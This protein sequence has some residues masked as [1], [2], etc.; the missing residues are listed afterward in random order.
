MVQV[1][2][3]LNIFA[4]LSLA[5][6]AL[7]PTP[8]P[9]AEVALQLDSTSG[10]VGE[11]L[12]AELTIANFTTVVPPAFPPL[13]GC[14]VRTS[15]VPSDSQFT[16]I[17]S[18][19]RTQRITRTYRFELTPTQA[20]TVDI[21]AIEIQVDGQTMKTAPAR[22]R[23][24]ASD[25]D[26][27]LWVEITSP[28]E[29]LYVGQ[30]VALKLTAF[31]KPA[32]FRGDPLDAA[33]MKNLFE[34]TSLPVFG[35]WPSDSVRLG[36]VRGASGETVYA[37]ELSAD[38]FAERPGR[39]TFDNLQIGMVYPLELERDFFSLRIRRARRL[40]VTPKVE[41]IDV[42]PLPTENRPAGF[43][44][45]VGRFGMDVSAR[46]RRVRVGDPIELTIDITSDG[47]LNAAPPPNLRANE[48]L[49]RDFRVPDEQLAGELVGERK[50]FTQV[51]RAT[52]ANVRQI[53]KLE[54]SYFDPERGRYATA[55]SEPIPLEV[56]ASEAVDAHQIGNVPPPAESPSDS[57]S[58][59]VDGLLANQDDIEQILKSTRPV[60]H[61]MA[62][63]VIAGPPV[64]YMFG[65]AAVGW[66]RNR[67][68]NPARLR[69]ARAANAADARLNAAQSASPTAVA[70]DVAA[71]LAQYLA[72]VLN[73]PPAHF[74]GG[75]TH[76]LEQAG[77]PQQTIAWYSQ[78]RQQCEAAA[79]GGGV[80][81]PDL[82]EQARAWI[83]D[84]E[85]KL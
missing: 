47:P 73:V 59:S 69:R 84:A 2:F 34:Q 41:S 7:A 18:G 11:P 21:P 22:I 27:L 26:D 50:R 82:V 66:L 43:T 42:L 4:A 49:L 17:I 6:A 1:S 83:Q 80:A 54:Y 77:L 85:Q 78:L 31:V 81:G 75:E 8:A 45:A 62:V 55:I 35:V 13:T 72:D 19:R 68:S 24:K 74:V 53:P 38:Y 32:A 60:S 79:F 20:G 25:A 52:S 44:G 36:Q 5:C 16:S 28:T 64:A 57:A 70:A 71:T 33:D 10:F 37:Y 46:P 65:W 29:R 76:E 40:R 9:A 58:L 3:R 63:A 67:S 12:N 14:D 61:A 23:V 39:L 51:V 56:A 48:A 15:G 30:H